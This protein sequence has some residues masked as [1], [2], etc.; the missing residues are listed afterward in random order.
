MVDDVALRFPL[1]NDNLPSTLDPQG[2][3][4]AGIV[5]ADSANLVI[6]DAEGLDFCEFGLDELVYAKFAIAVGCCQE[7]S[8]GVVEESFEVGSR[9]SYN[10]LG[11]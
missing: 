1:P 8:L 9:L 5:D 2:D 7:P 11:G 10:Q 4:G 3:P 6:P